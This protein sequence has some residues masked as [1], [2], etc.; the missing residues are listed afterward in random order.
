MNNTTLSPALS[1][2]TRL[3]TAFAEGELYVH[4]LGEALASPHLIAWNDSLAQELGVAHLPAQ[5]GEPALCQAF[6]GETALPHSQPASFVYSGHQFGHYVP[7]LGDGRALWLGELASGW[8]LQLKGSGLTPFSRMG[9]GKAVL[10]SSVREYVASEAMHALGIPTTRALCLVGSTTPVQRET[11][12]TAAVVTRVARSFLRFGTVEYLHHTQQHAVLERLLVYVMTHYYPHALAEVGLPAQVAELYKQVCQRTGELVA[13]WQ[14]V[15]F[16]HGVLNTDNMS[17]LGDTLDYGPYGF[18]EAFNP[19]FI[20][21]HS[22]HEGRYAFNQQPSIGAW[23]LSALGR[24]M[25]PW[26]TDD[27]FKT[28]QQAYTAS[29]TATFHNLMAK[30]LG[31]PTVSPE[32]LKPL[33]VAMTQ[34]QV[35]LTRWFRWLSTYEAGQSPDT[36]KQ[37]LTNVPSMTEW[38]ALY[39]AALAQS[40]TPTP[41]RHEAM[42][43]VNPLYVCRNYM[44]QEAIDGLQRDDDT[45]FKRLLAVLNSP[46]TSHPHAEAWEGE[47]PL[48]AGGLCVSCS[49]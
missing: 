31:L 36:F 19:A 24:A 12:E 15:G 39:N 8:E 23:N 6:T 18:M 25:S 47:P 42:Q 30:K 40:D 14:A 21:N 45:V 43:A 32:L 20:C 11:V 37:G 4:Q 13:H 5:L 9:D 44:A 48:W 49:S 7:R 27:T 1:W 41:L 10:R 38:L 34:G 17:L 3:T 28:G 16:A 35:E 26:L 33:F 46:Y 29:L 2:N 22:D